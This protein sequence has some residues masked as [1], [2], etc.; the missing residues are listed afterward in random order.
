MALQ[1]SEKNLMM[2]LGVALFAV[3]NF[4]GYSTLQE[5]KAEEEERKNQ[6][7]IQLTEY[8]LLN[9][10]RPDW[11]ARRIFLFEKC[12]QPSFVSE[13]AAAVEIEAHL[14]ACA[15]SAGVPETSLII[16]PTEMIATANYNQVALNVNASGS[17]M[18]IMKLVSLIQAANHS[19]VKDGT[20]KHG[21]YAIPNIQF[22]ADRKDP[23]ILKCAFILARWY[24]PEAAIGSSVSPNNNKEADFYA[25]IDKKFKLTAA[26]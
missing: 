24:S 18:S 1:Q 5:K 11:E 23:A 9:Q 26:K 15:L 12:P 6:L 7:D 22:E 14:K 19:N 8:E 13:E 16:K 4:V 25:T 20:L 10:I 17:A 3:I 21:F 2:I